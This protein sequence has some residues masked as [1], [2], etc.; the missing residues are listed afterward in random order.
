MK[1]IAWRIILIVPL[2]FQA[3]CKN[4]L[5]TRVEFITPL[6]QFLH[7]D[8][9]GTW[10]SMNIEEILDIYADDL[11]VELRDDKSRALNEF[12]I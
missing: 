4:W 11:A 1:C 3:S 10:E 9:A 7:H 12:K 5:D 6:N 8:Y 2:L